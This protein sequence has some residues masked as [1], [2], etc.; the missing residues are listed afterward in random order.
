MLSS[1][2]P[3][4]PSGGAFDLELS[5]LGMLL[6]TAMVG[7]LLS[8]FSSGMLV[9]RLGVA[10]LLIWSSLALVLSSLGYALAPGWPVMVAFGLLTGL[11]AGAVDAGVNAFAAAR[12]AP[13]TVTWL[14]A[15]YGVGAMLGPLLLTALMG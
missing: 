6:A 9:A 10:R 14:H 12:F 4:R 8:A 5:A 15:C 7:Y 1:V 11:G 3:G 2:W 13:R